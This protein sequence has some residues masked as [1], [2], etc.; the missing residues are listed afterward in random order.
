MG[1]RYLRVR[2]VASTFRVS[3]DVVYRWI[4][5]QRYPAGLVIRLGGTVRI[6]EQ[7]LNRL[8]ATGDLFTRKC[9]RPSVVAL[10]DP[11]QELHS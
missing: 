11:G 6:D 8:L 1:Q 5:E 4:R 7:V 3:S 9:S 10:T 2:E